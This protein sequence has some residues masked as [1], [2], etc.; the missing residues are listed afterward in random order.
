MWK[1]NADHMRWEKQQGC[2]VGHGVV[3]YTSTLMAYPKPTKSNMVDMPHA[4]Y[5]LNK[6]ELS[7]FQN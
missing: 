1:H 4:N 7:I 3:K 2:E 5:V 6:K